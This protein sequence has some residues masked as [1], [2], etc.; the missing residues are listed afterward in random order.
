MKATAELLLFWPSAVGWLVGLYQGVL[1]KQWVTVWESSVAY[2]S[3]AMT[4]KVLRIS[5]GSVC[6]VAWGFEGLDDETCQQGFEVK[7]SRKIQVNEAHPRPQALERKPNIG[8]RDLYSEQDAERGSS[9]EGK[10]EG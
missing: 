5:P 4:A 7:P 8:A 2:T 9:A 6:L 10:T 1:K 3:H